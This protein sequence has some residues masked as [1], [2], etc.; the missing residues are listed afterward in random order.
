M[1]ALSVCFMLQKSIPLYR[2]WNGPK[3]IH[4]CQLKWK[5]N[6]KGSASSFTE[7][8]GTWSKMI[9]YLIWF[10]HQCHLLLEP[11][12]EYLTK[13]NSLLKSEWKISFSYRQKESMLKLPFIDS[14]F[15]C[16]LIRKWAF[17]LL[18]QDFPVFIFFH[19]EEIHYC[20]A[21]LLF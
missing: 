8:F 5:R 16:F 13:L 19:A 1:A 7:V 3:M 18:N 17:P 12:E 6:R 9:H 11:L 2:Y 21:E 15:L 14:G 4:S 20:R 10:W